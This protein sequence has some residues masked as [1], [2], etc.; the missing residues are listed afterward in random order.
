MARPAW[1]RRFT[2]P[3]RPARRTKLNVVSLEDR[4]APAVFYFHGDNVFG[5]AHGKDD[6]YWVGD[7]AAWL[8]PYNW[9]LE[10][11]KGIVSGKGIPGSGDVAV[12]KGTTEDGKAW[13]VFE[14]LKT[15]GQGN[16][17]DGID[18]NG[19]NS[20]YTKDG[21][22]VGTLNLDRNWSP[23]GLSHTIT[24]TDGTG[25]R[26]N[27][28]GRW[29]SGA[30]IGNVINEG[31]IT[32]APDAN[33]TL[34]WSLGT[35]TNSGTV[36]VTGGT[37][38][39]GLETGI[40]PYGGVFDNDGGLTLAA[41]RIT[42]ASNEN[43]I[44]VNDGTLAGTGDVL[45]AVA[46]GKD[47]ILRST[48]ALNLPG[49]QSIEGTVIVGAGNTISFSGA[50]VFPLY[51]TTVWGGDV[52]IQG[53]GT[54]TVAGGGTMD[55]D[56]A[57]FAVAGDTTVRI[58]TP[59]VGQT[60]SRTVIRGSGKLAAG[61]TLTFDSGDF[62]GALEN[63][64]TLVFAGTSAPSGQ[65]EDYRLNGFIQNDG[66]LRIDTPVLTSTGTVVNTEAGLLEIQRDTNYFGNG[67]LIQ[68]FGTVRV[69]TGVTNVWVRA[70][71]DNLGGTI[72][73]RSGYVSLTNDFG[74]ASND[75]NTPRGA[76]FKA[77]GA[78]TSAT[79]ISTGG[80][81][82]V[83]KGA[84]LSLR[85]GDF[86]SPGGALAGAYTG[87]GGGTVRLGGHQQML[88]SDWNFPAGM[89]VWGAADETGT[90]RLTGTFTNSGDLS[91]PATT[92]S[93][94]R[95][96][97]YGTLTNRGTM[98]V[99]TSSRLDLFE[100]FQ[101]GPASFVNEQGGI[102]TFA[103]GNLLR[104]ITSNS[105]V[106]SLYAPDARVFLNRGL[107]RF[108]G[109]ANLSALVDNTGTFET[110]SKADVIVGDYRGPNPALGVDTLA[111]TWLVSHG[112]TMTFNRMFQV[113]S[114]PV[115]RTF[116]GTAVLDGPGSAFQ[117][118]L[119]L[120]RNAGDITVR[121][122]ATLKTGSFGSF[123]GRPDDNKFFNDGRLTVTGGGK[124]AIPGTFTQSVA[125]RLTTGVD[126]SSVTVGSATTLGGHYAAAT[127]PGFA[128][129]PGF[130][131]D[132]LTA[133][134][135]SGA[136][137]TQTLG[138]LIAQVTPTSIRLGLAT[139]AADLVVEDVHVS[140]SGDVA[141]GTPLSVTFTV[142]NL[143][144]VAVPAGWN[145]AVFLSAD[146]ALDAADT[147]LARFTDAGELPA[148][149][150]RT[151][152]I[153]FAAPSVPGPAVVIV[154][155]DSTA[156]V[157]DSNRSNNVA[158]APEP[159]RVTVPELPLGQDVPVNFPAGGTVYYSITRPANG[160][161][162]RVTAAGGT[163]AVRF[164][165]PPT[166][167]TADATAVGTPATLTVPNDHGGV[168]FLAVARNGLGPVTVRA[169]EA[170]LAI[171]GI[172]G[173]A[174]ITGRVVVGDTLTLT[175]R[176]TGF[177]PG[178]VF[179]LGDVIA[180]TTTVVDS[181]TAVVSFVV[182]ASASPL[183]VSAS[184]GAA[185]VVF[186][187]KGFTPVVVNPTTDAFDRMPQWALSINLP[188]AAR[189]RR[190]VVG[191]ITFRNDSPYAQPAPLLQLGAE[192]AFVRLA[193]QSF[194]L[195]KSMQVLGVK[196]D[197]GTYAPGEV[198]TVEFVLVPDSSIPHNQ[199]AAA[200]TVIGEQRFTSTAGPR[201]GTVADA[202]LP[203]DFVNGYRPETIPADPWANVVLPR[204]TSFMGTTYRS[205]A[206]ALR[207]AAATLAGDA[208]D[209]RDVGRLVTY[210]INLADDFGA[211]TARFT[212]SAFGRGNVNPFDLRIE[213]DAEG[214]RLVR[215]GNAIR[216][217]FPA[218]TAYEGAPGDRGVLTALAG[219]GWLL[220][221]PDG[222]VTAFRADG[223][224]DYVEGMAGRRTIASYADGRLVSL[225]ESN[226]DVTTLTYNATG[227]VASVRDAVGVET[228]YGYDASGELLS[229]VTTPRGT[230]TFE[231]HPDTTGPR[232]F[233][234]V[235]VTGPDGVRSAIEYD[236]LGRFAR[237]TVGG[238]LPTTFDYGETAD[239]GRVTATD[240]LGRATTSWLGETG[241][242]TRRRDALG[243]E[244][245]LLLD[246]RGYVVGVSTPESGF[247]AT[248]VD[249]N[250]R[251]SA[252]VDA[253]GNRTGF[254]YDASG[255]NAV[256]LR[257]AL[258]RLT[259][260]SFDARNLVTSQTDP[261]GTVSYAYDAAGN[262]TATVFA[263]GRA[264]RT[265]YN[266]ADL[267]TRVDYADGSAKTY[268][269]DARR[270]LTKVTD[271]DA[272]AANPRPVVMDYDAADRVTRVTYAT[273]RF[274]AYRYNAAGRLDRVTA[275]DGLAVDY[276]YDAVGRLQTLRSGG[277]L[278]VTYA[279][280]EAGRL[281]AK[282]FANGTS[283]AYEYDALGRVTRIEH[284]GPAGAVLTFEAYAYDTAGLVASVTTPSGTTAYGYDALGQLTSV[285]TP[286]GATTTYAYDAAGNRLGH[287]ANAANQY[288]TTPAGG[289]FAYDADGNLTAAT[290]PGL[291]QEQ[292][293]Y[294]AR[295]RLV[296]H[297]GPAGTFRYEYD[298]LGNRSAVVKNGVRTDFLL[299]PLGGADGLADVLAEYGGTTPS[300][301]YLIGLGLEG[302]FEGAGGVGF[303]HA[304]LQGSTTALTDASGAVAATYDYD[305]FGAVT[306]MTGAAAAANVYRFNGTLGVADRGTGTLDM[307]NRFYDPNTGRFT[308]RDPIGFAGGDAN[309]YRFAANNPV[310][311]V[312]PSGLLGFDAGSG[313]GIGG[314][315]ILQVERF[316]A[317]LGGEALG[318]YVGV[319]AE[320][321]GGV[322]VD[323]TIG[324]GSALGLT[325][326]GSSPNLP[327]VYEGLTG[328]QVAGQYLQA[329]S[330]TGTTTSTVA[331]V[332]GPR[333][334]GLTA[335]PVTLAV[336]GG[337]TVG[338]PLGV[339]LA[340]F[341][342]SVYEQAANQS[343][344]P[345]IPSNALI[346]KLKQQSL[347]D[348]SMADLLKQWYVDHPNEDPPMEWFYDR[349]KLLG[350]RLNG[351]ALVPV[352]RTG[353][354]GSKDPNDIV[355][356]AGFGASGFLQPVGPFGYTIRFQNQPSATAPAQVVTVTQQLDDDFDWESFELKT[357][358]WAG[359]EFAVPSGRQSYQTRVND[360]NRDAI[361]DVNATFN[362][363]TGLLTWTLT[364]LDPV[365]LDQPL[366]SV[367][368]GFLPPDDA[369]GVGQGFVSY[370][371]RPKA[372]TAT[373][374]RYDAQARIVFDTEA[375]IDTPAIFNT[376]DA[377]IP[378]VTVNDLPATTTSNAVTV[379][380]AGADDAGGS[381]LAAYDVFV[382]VNGGAWAPW[383]SDTVL[384]AS[385]YTGVAGQ[386]V[387]FYAT[388][389]DN[390]DL[391]SAVPPSAQATTK[392]GV[393]AATNPLLVGVPQFAVGGPGT[394]TTFNP[395][396]SVRFTLTPFPGFA[397]TIR[398]AV[399][400]VTGDG[401]G[402]V[403]VGTGPGGPTHVKVFDGVTQ[404]E[405]FSID[406]FEAS[407]TGGV[408]VA[409][410]DLTGDGKAE[411]VI[412]P[413]EGGGPRVRVFNADGFIQ[414][415]D[416]YGIDDPNFRGGARASV[417][418]LNGDGRGDLLVAAGFGGGPRVA[419]FDGSK[420]GGDGGPKLFGDFFAFEQSLRNGIFVAAGD[421]NGD[422]YAD[423]VAGGGPGG[424]PRVFLLDGKALVQSCSGNPVPVGN[425]F[426][427]D[428]DSRDGVRV[429]VKDLDGDAR[430]DVVASS[431]PT[432]VVAYRG[433]QTT[434][435]GGTPPAALDFDAL[436]GG[437][438]VG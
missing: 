390:V 319:A 144:G 121:N 300:A 294:D 190:D 96:M 372:N 362:P 89:L 115:V 364:T 357:F 182:P 412:T 198:G 175:V 433:S 26:V 106:A 185:P 68:N 323:I 152:T 276:G 394:V 396:G 140:P 215:V 52:R 184:N 244:S 30:V 424:G 237:T 191:S 307:R 7:G 49:P 414:L 263:S 119:G 288:T 157:L 391:V 197:G 395:D 413:D 80:T 355:G 226:G 173:A 34:S 369:T 46:T 292:F 4:L 104:G 345:P 22:A 74:P 84:T 317:Q 325:A 228:V 410:G 38:Q 64:G 67:G 296:Y 90:S 235:A 344:I 403:I 51:G 279:Y 24:M 69:N 79:G 245:D 113:P 10:T 63:D 358:G 126:A 180:A 331:S 374:T 261:H 335:G 161:P 60:G 1:L 318:S 353:I 270:N 196:P 170:G 93:L 373:G 103:G 107:V 233:A 371:V 116:R 6:A 146:D 253:A 207:A 377:G 273:G 25:L 425:Y 431:A 256:A 199:L 420:L 352:K 356:P 75:P 359:Y 208:G 213:T 275:S 102:V 194:A 437:I 254:T 303:Y 177:S 322:V 250:G 278:E 406:P 297:N 264:T 326:I 155:V 112:S 430:A 120:E 251:T 86:F 428:P 201:V 57:T 299:D 411:I 156:A 35:F 337:I 381:G 77:F 221:D 417:G 62:V 284:R 427:G 280:D 231:Y 216:P 310:T 287:G 117:G 227:R 281:A 147:R 101:P 351:E 421:V 83:A 316:I 219:G 301:N 404:R 436:A 380:W 258:G 137:A 386:T 382:S 109:S 217:F 44:I 87:A 400:D 309:F 214:N 347:T 340:K 127:P 150:S 98:N 289:S 368:A 105:S 312:D 169:D 100:D 66:T 241:A 286:A 138:G 142:R 350:L 131:A 72:D 405:L 262:R 401:V 15:D 277:I 218:G 14:G 269:Y 56:D 42:R 426:A 354:V 141:P 222:S 143:S 27:D 268:E 313:F 255:A 16:Y 40:V 302:R 92:G 434:P 11:E 298:A 389:R 349:F 136:F 133:T 342:Q 308:Q 438:Y 23:P 130:T 53:G 266:A 384:T 78:A 383:L 232:A 366:D 230:T 304:N 242:I 339:G 211:A 118:L 327:A 402:D 110:V 363:A 151:V 97:R 20:A 392:L 224:M 188:R 167:D 39:L 73:V 334:I 41:G 58:G 379:S 162:V 271:L 81:F 378:T 129:A 252:T 108:A 85:S 320:S 206:S 128:P 82:A 29:Q 193:S 65:I 435:L 367:T 148:Y 220:A 111:G 28:G 134:A 305:A 154:A 260:Q 418:D 124:L 239:P 398:I 343:G 59:V 365:T 3:A 330:I 223:F 272:G 166:G 293:G 61:G 8:N 274:V 324:A 257:D 36:T 306:D 399:A 176:G 168:Y 135:V 259:T 247:V 225:T 210:L 333:L 125:G 71:F 31:G 432:R 91:L 178:T 149:G 415:A 265:T 159:L 422:G 123:T 283:T 267:P 164:A 139:D 132:V 54:M 186:T 163:A 95:S 361:V 183:F 45:V 249:A 47:G 19:F 33:A 158:S 114:Q 315:A 419:A 282:A 236:G 172:D 9:G 21:I 321:V 153:P 13:T 295:G 311:F 348:R 409:A 291:S 12:F 200:A 341:Y 37:F 238:L 407:F 393:A 174:T 171:T 387:A 203:A 94:V 388:T 314:H 336:Q 234:L 429:A 195:R 285:T 360:P 205:F 32:V 179:R 76:A 160:A 70:A 187:G 248:P 88:Q 50:G 243:R 209:P 328:A 55:L 18:V 408:Y 376:A 246:D 229:S 290:D 192:N 240:S 338:R 397:G 212:L 329:A 332:A 99:G 204:L 2:R 181:T 43:T 122:G 385:T 202:P 189:P 416:F 375:P 145:D 17:I 5:P 423:V 48:K 165:Q 346:Q 370:S